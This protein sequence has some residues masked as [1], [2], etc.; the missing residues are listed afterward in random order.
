MVFNA[1]FNNS[2]VISW[3]SVLLVE[4]TR[5]LTENHWPTTSHWQ[6]LSHIVVSSTPRL[7]GNQIQI[8]VVIGTDCICM[9]KM[10]PICI[11]HGTDNYYNG[12]CLKRT[13]FCVQ[14]TVK[15]LIFAASNFHGFSQLDKFADTFFRI[16]LI[17]Q[18]QTKKGTFRSTSL[19][20]DDVLYWQDKIVL[21]ITF[22][23][24]NL[25]YL[26]SKLTYVQSL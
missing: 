4:E 13:P 1:T 5:V 14:N 11:H 25:F 6:T 10:K 9:Y 8:L 12:I 16:F 21:R 22:A 20:A 19:L 15:V 3:Q 18:K 7:S 24:W 17:A 2:S 26:N 23:M